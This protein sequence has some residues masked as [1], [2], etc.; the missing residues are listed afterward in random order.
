[1]AT[2]IQPFT[3][4]HEE[5]QRRVRHPLALV[6]SHIRRYIILEGLALTLLATAAIFGTSCA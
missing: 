4:N 5:S 2:V 3:F 6:R 1:M